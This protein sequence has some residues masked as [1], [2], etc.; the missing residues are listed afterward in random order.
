M[1]EAAKAIVGEWL[2]QYSLPKL[3]VR[4]VEHP[5]ILNLTEILAVV[6]PRR[7]GKTFFFFQLIRELTE[8]RGVTRDRILFVDFEDYRMSYLGEDP[9][10]ELLSAF[11]QLTGHA[12]E[13]LFLDEVQQL[14]NWSRV[15]RTLH[16][17][18]AF[19]III[20]GSN[21]KLLSR[22]VSTELRGRC[23]E[24]AMY[25]FSFSEF[26]RFRGIEVNQSM[27][28]T[29]AKGRIVGAFEDYLSRGGFPGV[30]ACDSA[31]ER[32]RIL[33]GYY[34]T[35]YYK[36]ILERYDIRAKETL[37]SM[38]RNAV[39]QAGEMFS[40]SAFTKTLSQRGIDCSKR[41]VANYL[42]YLEEAFFVILTE[43]FAYSQRQRTANQVK[44]YLFDTGF[45]QLGVNFSP[46]K[47]KLLENLVAI[48]LRRRGKE[49]FYYRNRGECDFIV[50]NGERPESAI[51]V[52]WEINEKNRQR[53]VGGLREAMKSLGVKDAL[54][55][56]HEGVAAVDEI[57]QTP[58]WR[59]LLKLE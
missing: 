2:E 12:P 38:M 35:T 1:S 3:V 50:M 15:V 9:A 41:T 31:M 40:I 23:L 7:S 53:E 20:S 6:G 59:W 4:D 55:L 34:Q 21:S 52:C 24:V 10:G 47:G 22:E 19:K 25:P 36:D 33:Q 27:V 11:E 46:N 13:Y 16:N 14:P 45:K 37:S 17:R 57:S 48:E 44:C 39:D 54:I 56:S 43:K 32:R 29:S 49:F 51:Q 18:R 26:L 5:D 8:R 30:A 42:A 28:H 58:V